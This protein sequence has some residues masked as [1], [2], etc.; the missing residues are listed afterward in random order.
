LHDANK[1]FAII[2]QEMV[3]KSWSTSRHFDHHE[4]KFG[5]VFRLTFFKATLLEQVLHYVGM[6]RI[7]GSGWPDIQPFFAIR[8][9]FRPKY[10]LSPDS[11]T[12]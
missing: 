3:Q 4:H 8:F 12:R 1:V 5:R 6:Y 9:R 10:C 11:A 2:M 7:S